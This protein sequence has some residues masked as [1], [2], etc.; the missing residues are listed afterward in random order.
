MF[1]NGE[2]AAMSRLAK[3]TATGSLRSAPAATIGQSG[4]QATRVRIGD[5]ALTAKARRPHRPGREPR[6]RANAD[7]TRNLDLR[8]RPGS[9]ET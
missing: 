9:D 8:H 5:A 1:K 4:H 2:D 7:A 6:G 3:T